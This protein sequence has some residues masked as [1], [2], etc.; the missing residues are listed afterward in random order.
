MSGR[1]GRVVAVGAGAWSVVLACGL[2]LGPHAVFFAVAALVAGA[3]AA[4]AA[5]RVVLRPAREQRAWRWFAPVGGVLAAGFGFEALLLA[6]GATGSLAALLPQGLA[7]SVGTVSAC[8]LL[9]EAT[10]Y[11]NRYGMDD[12]DPGEWVAGIGG[13]VGATAL[14]IWV[15]YRADPGLPPLGLALAAEVLQVAAL[16]VVLLALLVIIATARLRSDWRAWTLCG[17][18]AVITGLQVAWY[19]DVVR[20]RGGPGPGW[21]AVAGVGAWLALALMITAASAAPRVVNAATFVSSR[22]SAMGGLAVCGGGVGLVVLDTLWPSGQQSVAILGALTMLIGS[23]RLVRLVQDVAELASARREARTDGLTGIANRRA[24]IERL[25]DRLVRTGRAAL[26]MIDLDEFKGINDGL[27]HA[28]GD[29]LIQVVAGRLAAETSDG[30]LLARLG[31]DEFAVVLDDPEP[32]RAARVG[33]SLL[34]ALRAPALIAG[35]WVRVDA[36]VGV[37]S[38]RFGAA[39]VNALLHGADAAMYTAKRSGGGVEVYDEAASA[40]NDR[41]RDLLSDLRSLLSDEARPDEALHDEALPLAGP[42]PVLEPPREGRRPD[43]TAPVGSLVL[44]YQPQLACADGAVVGIE[45]LVRWDH[46][47]HGLLEPTA[48]LDLVEDHRLMPVLT[49]MVIERAAAEAGRWRAAGRDLPVAVNLS[50]SCL[51]R[52]EL[53]GELS[54]ALRA[55]GLPADRL[56]LE[57]TETA[58]MREPAEA[59]GMVTALGAL[60]VR[61]SIDDY[62]TG[63]SSLAYLDQLPAHELKLDRS[64]TTRLLD[65]RRTQVIVAG[66]IDLAHRLGLQVTAEGVEDRATADALRE[67]GCDRTQGFLHSRPLPAREL[68]AWLATAPGG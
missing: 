56:V 19:V 34:D 68:R 8:V 62:G 37:A 61:V 14:T 4:V 38:T 55:S 21:L 39:G 41:R 11:W 36:S 23:L 25:D 44:H 26:L 58:I 64:F 10:Q 20:D 46:P 42:S 22:A 6:V 52:A 35:S 67:L 13:L 53:L 27:G 5:P 31:G 66:T 57:V 59:V 12:W 40:L 9:Y 1:S 17:L 18:L 3:G 54:R 15:T 60:G 43:G 51:G 47:R 32:E 28:A 2:V 33:V 30:A 7:V 24:L 48:F 16:A 63:Y 65:D 45:A 50:A 49:R 29:E